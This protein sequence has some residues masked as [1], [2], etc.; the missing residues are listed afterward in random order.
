ML[1]IDEFKLINDRFGHVLGDR[2]LR[3]IADVLK[4]SVKGRHIVARYGGEEFALL[5]P[6]TP[7]GGAHVLAEQLREAVAQSRILKVNNDEI[8]GNITISAGLA[9]YRNGESGA[10]FIERSAEALYVS[11]KTGRNRLTVAG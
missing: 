3:T 5:L 9:C 4:A 7:L 10:R 8:V 11:K 1:D 2:V 6:D